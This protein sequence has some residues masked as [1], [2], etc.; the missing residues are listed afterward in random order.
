[1]R[2]ANSERARRGGNEFCGSPVAELE[3]RVLEALA[4]EQCA[5]FYADGVGGPEGNVRGLWI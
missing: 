1:M 3:D 5:K 2:V 4:G